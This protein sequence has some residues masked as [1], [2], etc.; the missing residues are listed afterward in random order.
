LNVF[1]KEDGSINASKIKSTFF[2][3]H[4]PE[5]YEYLNNRFSDL[6]SIENFPEILYRLIHNIDYIPVCP[7]C[8]NKIPFI[9]NRYNMVCSEECK[10][11]EIYKQLFQ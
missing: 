1:Y 7:V 11:S 2:K 3:K 8:G 4:H 9:N 5:L 6:N 10:N